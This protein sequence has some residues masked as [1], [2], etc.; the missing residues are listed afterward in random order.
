MGDIPKSG[1]GVPSSAEISSA[2]FL[3]K[4]DSQVHL[5]SSI[6]FGERS[7]VVLSRFHRGPLSRL[8]FGS[9]VSLRWGRLAGVLG[10]PL[11]FGLVCHVSAL[12]PGKRRSQG[13]CDLP[14]RIGTSS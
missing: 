4:R 7:Q 9:E 14:E 1:L 3:G 2:F 13:C 5:S 6:T 8:L 12:V 10:L 11:G